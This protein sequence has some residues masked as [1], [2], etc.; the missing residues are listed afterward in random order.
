MHLLSTSCGFKMVSR[1]PYKTLGCAVGFSSAW[2]KTESSYV[3]NRDL[4][5]RLPGSAVAD[6]SPLL[7][8]LS[9]GPDQAFRSP[10]FASLW[11]LRRLSTAGS[12]GVCVHLVV[13]AVGRPVARGDH[14]RITGEM[15]SPHS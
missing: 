10:A 13:E 7:L 3:V 15:G 2:M 1:D 4:K 8:S 12:A 9:I 6:V 5:G 14:G 11:F